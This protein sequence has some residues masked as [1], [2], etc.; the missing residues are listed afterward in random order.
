MKRE[1]TDCVKSYKYQV[2]SNQSKE[3]SKKSKILVIMDKIVS[4][5]VGEIYRFPIPQRN[6][7]NLT[8]TATVIFIIMH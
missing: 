2:T 3:R 7:F 5:I 1:R 6:S 4:K 8:E